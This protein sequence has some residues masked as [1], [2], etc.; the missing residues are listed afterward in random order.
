MKRTPLSEV[1]SLAAKAA[2][3]ATA[4]ATSLAAP[5]AQAAS[6]DLDP[7]FADHGRLAAILGAEGAV[8][9]IEALDGGGAF[10]A[11]ADLDFNRFCYF[12]YSCSLETSSFTDLLDDS[13]A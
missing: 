4:V 13:G 8:Y 11:G 7:S 12:Y 2:A 10:V 1:I 3:P 5:L 9:S 6:G